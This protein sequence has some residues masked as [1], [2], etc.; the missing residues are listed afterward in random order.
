MNNRDEPIKTIDDPLLYMY[1]C[2][3]IEIEGVSN[4]FKKEALLNSSTNNLE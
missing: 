4:L 1:K 2:L 3:K